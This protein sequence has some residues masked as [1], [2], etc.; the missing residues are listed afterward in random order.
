MPRPLTVQLEPAEVKFALAISF[1]AKFVL[2]RS[3]VLQDALLVVGP[4]ACFF[5]SVAMSAVRIA[6]AVVKSR[7]P[8]L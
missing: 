3:E 8:V 6:A 1:I 7:V 4:S 5:F 2:M